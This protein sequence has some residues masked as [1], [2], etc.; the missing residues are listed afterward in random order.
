MAE[1]SQNNFSSRPSQNNVM[2]VELPILAT[3]HAN[4]WQDIIVIPLIFGTLFMFA[5]AASKMGGKLQ[6]VLDSGV[7]TDL[8]HLPEYALR[9]TAR[10]MMA[11]A[12]AWCFSLIYAPLAAKYRRAELLLIPALDIMQSVPI[13]SY[14]AF[15]FTAL[16]ALF[17]GRLVGVEI[18]CIFAI[19]TSQVWNITFSLY[20][21]LLTVPREMVE[22]AN[23]FQLNTWQ[24][25]WRL[26]LPFAMPGLIWNTMLSLSG[27]WF[28]VVAAEAVTISDK[29]I[30]LPGIGSFIALAITERNMTAILSAV[31]T[32]FA[33]IVLYDQ[34]LFRPLVVW[35]EKFKVEDVPNQSAPRSMVWDMF[36]S[37]R[38]YQAFGKY[39]AVSTRIIRRGPKGR[40]HGFAAKRQVF[41]ISDRTQDIV[42]FSFLGVMAVFLIHRAA[43]FIG[44]EVSW[45]EIGHIFILG[46]FTAIRVVTMISLG[47]LVWVPLGVWI[48]LRPNVAAWIQPIAQIFAAFPV[49]LIYPVV[50]VAIVTLRLEPNI[51]LSF[52]MIM[53]TQW[54]LLFNVVAGTLAFPTDL[55]DAAKGFGIHGVLWWRKIILPGIFPYLITGVITAAGGTWNAAIVAETVQWGGET[56]TAQGL[57]SYIAMATTGGDYRRVLIGTIIMSLFVVCFNRFVWRRLYRIAEKKLRLG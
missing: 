17:P 44:Q 55:R 36:R 57:G 13:L 15:T 2:S 23:I 35:A 49:N 4:G 20:Q 5:W 54:Y 43:W 12:A 39:A 1:S 11:L 40:A 18:A 50:V 34:L 53:G 31:L 21:S 8:R 47:L 48:G 19:F 14:I 24:K 32:M 51:W 56:V 37:S 6:P 52:L 26:E 46:I 38:V 16:L 45:A 33:V 29:H 27:G 28:F 41:S 7:S 22:A 30:S 3:K 25:F 10:M 42:I 9:T